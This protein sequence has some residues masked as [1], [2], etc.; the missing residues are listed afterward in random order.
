EVG[1]IFAQAFQIQFAVA[2][3]IR[4]ADLDESAIGGEAFQALGDKAARQGIEHDID[5]AAGGYI[6]DL[7]VEVQRPRIEDLLNAQVAQVGLF[8][9]R[10]GGGDDG[11]ASALRQLNRRAA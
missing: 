5:A 2:I 4:L 3:D 8:V 10:P 7:V 6:H 1:D 9:L 11:H